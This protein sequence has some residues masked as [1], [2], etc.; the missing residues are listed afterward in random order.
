MSFIILGMQSYDETIARNIARHCVLEAAWDEEAHSEDH[1]V[2]LFWN[3]GFERPDSVSPVLALKLGAE[4]YRGQDRIGAYA[5]QHSVRNRVKF[6][7]KCRTRSFAMAQTLNCRGGYML[8]V[9][10]CASDYSEQGK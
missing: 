6:R 2:P 9:S 8:G 4:L 1:L 5:S 10:R 3:H 7:I